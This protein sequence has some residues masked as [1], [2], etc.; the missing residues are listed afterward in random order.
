MGW[1]GSGGG[2]VGI[3]GARVRNDI[4]GPSRGII[5]TTTSLAKSVSSLQL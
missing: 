5:K 4:K 3:S 2:Q 1:S